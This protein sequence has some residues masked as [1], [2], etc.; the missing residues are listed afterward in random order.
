[1]LWV[2]VHYHKMEYEKYTMMHIASSLKVGRVLSFDRICKKATL[3]S[4]QIKKLWGSAKHFYLDEY[5]LF[6]KKNDLALFASGFLWWIGYFAEI[7][8]R[9]CCFFAR[10]ICYDKLNLAHYANIMPGKN[11]WIR[12]CGFPV[13]KGKMKD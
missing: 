7:F 1:M 9:A 13:K 12:A 10:I 6:K 8:P 4:S 2:F 11:F 3:K 5:K